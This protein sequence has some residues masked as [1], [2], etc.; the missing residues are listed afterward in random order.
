MI[1]TGAH[2]GSCLVYPGKQL[3]AM[4]DNCGQVSSLDKLV[5]SITRDEILY[6]VSPGRIY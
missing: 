6:R 3:I 5:G 4:T 2:F 1:Y